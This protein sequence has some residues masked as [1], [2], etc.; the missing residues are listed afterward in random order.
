[1]EFAG[2]SA[3]SQVLAEHGFQKR[4]QSATL[5]ADTFGLAD[6]QVNLSCYFLTLK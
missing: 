3:K 2:N 6:D 4:P 1:M 5:H